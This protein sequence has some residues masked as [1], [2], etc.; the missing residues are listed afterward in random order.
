MAPVCHQGDSWHVQRSGDGSSK[1][2]YAP[3]SSPSPS[4]ALT[5]L[6]HNAIPDCT[7]TPVSYIVLMAIGHSTARQNDTQQSPF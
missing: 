3:R 7:R 4:W 6:A 2:F 1:A 5:A